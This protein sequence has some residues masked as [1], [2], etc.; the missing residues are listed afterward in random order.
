M[1]AIGLAGVAVGLIFGLGLQAPVA[2]D[3]GSGGVAVQAPPSAR[4]PAGQAELQLAELARAELVSLRATVAAEQARLND[5]LVQ[6]AAAE[7]AV[8]RLQRDLAAAPPPP[9]AVPVA[10][11]PRPARSEPAAA[12]PPASGQ[13]RVFVHMRAGSIAAADAAA[14]LADQIRD[15]GFTLAEVR[16]VQGTPSQRVVRYFHAEDAA[17]AARLAGRLGRGWA[18]QD[19]RT[20][21]PA[22]APQTL[23]IW[24]PDR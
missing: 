23:E 11:P 24:L 14:S 1:V 16:E 21:E 6:R 15:S 2:P 10:P 22:P 3:R 4:A 18:I 8:A 5:I 9:P 12:S 13:P 17:A 20:F 19:F 7:A